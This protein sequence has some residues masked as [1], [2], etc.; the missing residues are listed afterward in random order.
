[1]YYLLISYKLNK[2]NTSLSV[3]F[4]NM[5]VIAFERLLSSYLSVIANIQLHHCCTGLIW[6]SL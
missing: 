6:T 1:M 4:S 3:L 2:L 5:A